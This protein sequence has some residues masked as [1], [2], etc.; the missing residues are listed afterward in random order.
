MQEKKLLTLLRKKK[1]F[2]EAIL[3]LTST[4]IELSV[5]DWVA[6]LEQKKILLSCIDEID[7]QLQPFQFALHNLSQEAAEELDGIKTVIQ[8]ILHLDTLN[9]EKRKRDLKH[10]GGEFKTS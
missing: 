1:G 3:D 2:F 6:S 4:E 8:H 7:E 5:Q 9:Q 10:A